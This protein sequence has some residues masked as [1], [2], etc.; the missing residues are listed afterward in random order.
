MDNTRNLYNTVRERYNRVKEEMNH[1]D[2]RLSTFPDYTRSIIIKEIKGKCYYY[3][4]WRQDGKV[5]T[6]YLSPV[7]P[8]AV[9]AVEAEL[10]EQKSLMMQKE[11]ALRLNTYLERMLKYMK[12]DIEKE[13]VV[14]DHSFE[15]FWKDEIVSRISVRGSRAYISRF[16]THPARQLFA[17]GQ[18]SRD[19]VN[20]VLEM[21]CW[22]RN[23]PDLRDLLAH[24]G[25]DDYHPYEIVRRTHGVSWNDY[26]WFRFPG[27]ALTAKDVLVRT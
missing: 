19:Q 2:S 17:A 13:K 15:L 6:M 26:L 9:A 22:D 14:E 7:Y 11:Q 8:G 21:R 4:Q 12:K 5:N 3:M 25:L 1:I 24:I 10:E 20:R 18:M 27:E 16:T 23:R